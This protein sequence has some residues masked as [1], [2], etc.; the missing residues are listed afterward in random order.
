M[1]NPAAES[2]EYELLDAGNGRQLARFGD[3]IVDR[4]YPAAIH[5]IADPA[6]WAMADLRYERPSFGGAGEWIAVANEVP[7]AWTMRHAGMTFELRPTTSGQVGFFGE[8]ADLWPWIRDA[9]RRLPR[10]AVPPAPTVPPAIM[11]FPADGEAQL[12]AALQQSARRRRPTASR[13]SSS[14]RRSLSSPVPPPPT[15]PRSMRLPC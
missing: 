15:Q 6:A 7:E 1:E 5:P 13:R 14:S 9:V 11:A 12:A 8:Q 4:P 3:L 10:T 2:S